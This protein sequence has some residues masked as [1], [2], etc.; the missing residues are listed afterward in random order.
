MNEAM[1]EHFMNA[2][3]AEDDAEEFGSPVALATVAGRCQETH[4]VP[5]NRQHF[6]IPTSAPSTVEPERVEMNLLLGVAAGMTGG[7]EKTAANNE[8]VMCVT[9]ATLKRSL[10][11]SGELKRASAT[12]SQEPPANGPQTRRLRLKPKPKVPPPP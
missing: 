9:N 6:T 3:E 8:D 11:D 4:K 10:D 5:E 2:A 7:Q 1:V 12:N